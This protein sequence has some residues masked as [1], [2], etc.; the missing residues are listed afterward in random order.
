M[1][2]E[3]AHAFYTKNDEFKA[4][5]AIKKEIEGV[6]MNNAEHIGIPGFGRFVTSHFSGAGYDLSL[7]DDKYSK[8]G[9][10]GM[11]KASLD[12]MIES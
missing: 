1:S 6:D 2:F 9:N 5:S 12:L 7:E 4:S 8:Y 3:R 11:V 10:S